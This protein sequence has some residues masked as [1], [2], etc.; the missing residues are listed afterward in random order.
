MGA[1]KRTYALPAET[2]QQFERQVLPG[3][4]STVIARLIR[5]WVDKQKRERLREEVIQGCRDMA[6]LYLEVEREYHPLEEE[7]QSG[8]DNQPK[9]R[10]RRSG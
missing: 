3:Q 4:R 9:T 2:L 8:L 6:E 5:D 7:V 1:L 10:R